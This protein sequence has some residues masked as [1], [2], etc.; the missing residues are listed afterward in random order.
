MTGSTIERAIKSCLL[1]NRFKKNSAFKHS[2]DKNKE[3]ELS[4]LIEPTNKAETTTFAQME[5]EPLP[6]RG[7]S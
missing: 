5:R 1:K 4:Q 7:V 6:L 2:P 3:E